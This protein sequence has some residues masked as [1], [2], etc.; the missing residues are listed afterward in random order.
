MADFRVL[1]V[2]PAFIITVGGT[3]SG[4]FLPKSAE[5]VARK[6]Q[7]AISSFAYGWTKRTTILANILCVPFVLSAG[8]ALSAYVGAH[9]AVLSPWLI[10][11][12]LTVLVQIHTTPGNSLLLAYGKTTPLLVTSAVA[13]AVSM[14]IN[15]VLA[16]R[17]GAGAAVVGYFVYVIVVIGLYYVTYYK[18]LMRLSR[19]KMFKS[20]ALPTAVSFAVVALVWLVPV[21]LHIPSLGDRLNWILVCLLKT[22]L[23]LGPYLGALV[24][25]RVIS[26]EEL[27]LMRK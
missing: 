9:Y 24:L 25:M 3:F 20:F 10:L 13:C 11:W 23:W 8:E 21:E 7:A 18:K 19:W 2:I 15:I 16:A 1:E 5:M 26:R 22:L 4:I 14:L 6:D 27:R 12:L 17:Y